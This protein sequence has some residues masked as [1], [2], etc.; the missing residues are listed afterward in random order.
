M[1][2]FAADRAQPTIDVA[3]AVHE[4]T[5]RGQRPRRVLLIATGGPGA[6]GIDDGTWM[7]DALDDRIRRAFDV[8]TFDARGVGLSDGRDCPGAAGTYAGAP[9]TA[10]SARALVEGC[11]REAHADG[12]DLR[13]YATTQVVED[14]DAVRRALG[15]DRFTLYGS[16]Y[17]TV[18]AQAYAAA[19]PDRLDGLVLDAPIDRTLSATHL[20]SVAAHGFRHAV[21]DT[22]AWCSADPDC[23]QAL[24]DAGDTYRR[25]LEQF[26]RTGAIDAR[27][28]GPDGTPS[29]LTLT[30]SE[31]DLM[32]NSAMYGTTTRTSWLRALAA[33]NRADRRPL[34]HLFDA[35][36]GPGSGS[37]FG[38]YATWC[39]DVRASPTARD[40]DFDGY[41]EALRRER[42]DDPSSIDVAAAIAP[43][44]FWPAQPASSTTPAEATT[45]PT[46]ILTASDD[47][48][49]PVGEAEAIAARL[50]L[51]RLIETQGGGHGSLGTGC[52]D[53][54]MADFVVDARLPVG[55]A[56]VCPGRVSDPFVPLADSPASTARSAATGLIRELIA[57][58]EVIDWDGTAPLR[59]G[60]ADGGSATLTASPAPG[61]P[62]SRAQVTL[63]GCAWVT[64][65]TFD[66][67]GTLDIAT[68]DADLDLHATRGDIEVR[69]RSGSLTVTGTWDGR[70]AT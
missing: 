6:S 11:I 10:E 49:T 7:I 8:V 41:L 5:D 70:P 47:P 32:T 30:R 3:Y 20:W 31:F 37:T 29:T 26:D 27:V 44:V 33:V 46:L 16:S 34:V 67:G 55:A 1:D 52:A 42:V 39:A 17:G 40:D 23:G 36:S 63:D 35:W 68:G 21:Q 64:L 54:R 56:S 4:A 19:H 50:P 61:V 15:I 13:R 22:L 51:A 45:V 59:V 2:H 48:I 14:I 12:E 9:L 18:V 25:L 24:P 65:A 60:C 28:T 43:C 66:G 53:E 57:A 62:P 58:P 38:Y 69:S